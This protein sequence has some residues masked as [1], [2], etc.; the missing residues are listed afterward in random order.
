MKKI[1]LVLVLTAAIYFSG[2][3][4]VTEVD[5]TGKVTAKEYVDEVLQKARLDFSADAQLA[6]IYGWNVNPEGKINLL[7]TS[8]I[9]VYVVQSDSRQENAFYVPVFAAGPIESP[10][11][12][13]TMLSFVKDTVASKI[14]GKVFNRLSDLAIDPSANYKDSPE[15]IDT[16]RAHGGLNFLTQNPGSKID[17]FLLP[18]KSID[19]TLTVNNSADWIVNFYN[20]TKSLVLWIRSDNGEVIPLSGN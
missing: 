18:S 14:L 5:E 10:I 1:F 2:C 7:E 8:N 19:T 4:K 15:T 12:F 17:M 9:F 11:N 3:D 16:A 20:D 13:T 6:A